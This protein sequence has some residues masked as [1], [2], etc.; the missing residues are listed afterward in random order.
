MATP[1]EGTGGDT[2]DIYGQ[3][4]SFMPQGWHTIK[5]VLLT[6]M[7]CAANFHHCCEAADALFHARL[8]GGQVARENARFVSENEASGAAAMAEEGKDGDTE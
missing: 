3:H 8:L 1:S 6:E 2:F 4:D 7:K 5:S